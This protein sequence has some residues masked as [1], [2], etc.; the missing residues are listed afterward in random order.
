MN[1]PD[2]GLEKGEQAAR[3]FLQEICRRG[4]VG[5]VRA[6]LDGWPL[7]EMA[8]L[9]LVL[10]EKQKRDFPDPRH[11]QS[12]AVKWIAGVEMLEEALGKE[13]KP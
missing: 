1:M 8:T 7:G 3:E 9:L 12:G 5:A 2:L 4:N 11:P 13:A 6:F 10:A